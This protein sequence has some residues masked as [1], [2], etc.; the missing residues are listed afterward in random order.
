MNCFKREKNSSH[1]EHRWIQYLNLRKPVAF[2][3]NKTKCITFYDEMTQ[4]GDWCFPFNERGNKY[5]P[6]RTIRRFL[7]VLYSRNIWHPND[8]LDM[9]Q[10]VRN[11]ALKAKSISQRAALLLSIRLLD[12]QSAARLTLQAA[13]VHTV[14]FTSGPLLFPARLPYQY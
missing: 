10:Y 8:G 2:P 7:V 13:R 1:G 12:E 9:T 14:L 4:F 6:S 11:V 3:T 5:H